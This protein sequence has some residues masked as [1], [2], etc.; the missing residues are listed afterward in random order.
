MT[1]NQHHGDDPPNVNGRMERVR[2]GVDGGGVHDA[3]EASGAPH[4]AIEEM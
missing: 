3:L 4:M 1:N 2:I